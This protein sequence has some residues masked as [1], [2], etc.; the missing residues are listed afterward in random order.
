MRDTVNLI[1]EGIPAVALLHE[2][3]RQ[4]A[5]MAARQVGMPETPLLVYPRDLISEETPEQLEEKAAS[6]A[7]QAAQLLLKLRR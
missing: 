6:V 4:L 3:F 1:R 5:N 2:P 7:D